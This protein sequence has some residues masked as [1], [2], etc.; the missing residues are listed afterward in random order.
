ME[1]ITKK[2][3]VIFEIMKCAFIWPDKCKN[4]TTLN[5]LTKDLHFKDIHI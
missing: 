2:C 1:A 4:R 3:S 5:Y